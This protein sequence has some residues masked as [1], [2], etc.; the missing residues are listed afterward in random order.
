MDVRAL[1]ASQISDSVTAQFYL[2]KGKY[3]L[4]A[5]ACGPK[6]CEG[7][8]ESE[9]ARATPGPLAPLCICFFLPPGLPYVI[10]PARSAVCST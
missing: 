2:D 4:E 7:K 8:R 5:R 9:H 6:R 3:V 1:G 10:G